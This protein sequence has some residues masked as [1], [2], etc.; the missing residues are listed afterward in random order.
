MRGRQ[1]A[2]GHIN[3]INENDFPLRLAFDVCML[4]FYVCDECPSS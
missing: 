4:T 1:A 3:L 2:G